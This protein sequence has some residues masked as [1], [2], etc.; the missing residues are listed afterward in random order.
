[1]FLARA[2][3]EW[4]LGWDGEGMG[5]SRRGL[6]DDAGRTRKRGLR[7]GLA[8]RKGKSPRKNE[9]SVTDVTKTRTV[10]PPKTSRFT[11]IVIP[12]SDH[13]GPWVVC[14]HT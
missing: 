6:C 1:M 7:A 4:Q 3:D 14:A 13:R 2:A 11:P 9:Y 10:L 5:R 12:S 8:R